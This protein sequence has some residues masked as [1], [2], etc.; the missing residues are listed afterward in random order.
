MSGRFSGDQRA[1]YAR[2]ADILLPAAHGLP[3]G[4][5]ADVAGAGLDRVIRLRPDI[6]ADLLRAIRLFEA[7]AGLAALQ[8]DAEVWRAARLAAFSAYFLAPAVMERLG[9]T[10]Q[11]SH[12]FDAG[13]VPEYLSNGSLAQ[14]TDRGPIWR[15]PAS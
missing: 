5:D 14:V 9:Y 8:A 15:S 13:Q 7:D 12:P 1:A 6:V 2:L 10:G 11:G 3:S 4:S